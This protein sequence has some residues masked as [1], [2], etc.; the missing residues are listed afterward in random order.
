MNDELVSWGIVRSNPQCRE[1]MLYDWCPSSVPR[2]FGTLTLF[3]YDQH[4]AVADFHGVPVLCFRCPSSKSNVL[5]KCSSLGSGM[6][7]K[8][9]SCSN[10]RLDPQCRVE[11]LYG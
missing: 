11:V 9:A 6:N 1:D 7:D 8:L 4:Y 10:V 3:D 2:S 5:R